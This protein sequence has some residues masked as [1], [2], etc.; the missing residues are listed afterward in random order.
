MPT[1]A[2]SAR[3]AAWRMLETVHEGRNTGRQVQRRFSPGRVFTVRIRARH[4]QFGWLDRGRIIAP[5]A[6]A[7]RWAGSRSTRTTRGWSRSL[8]TS[9]TPN[10]HCS[11]PPADSTSPYPQTN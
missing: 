10:G 8:V 9:W 2:D 5:K 11:K 7:P 4:P 6:T 1:L 3:T